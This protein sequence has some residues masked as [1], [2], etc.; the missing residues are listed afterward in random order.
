[1][2]IASLNERAEISLAVFGPKLSGSFKPALAL[3][4]GRF[5]GTAANGPVSISNFL[6]V[7]SIGLMG[8]I[9]FLL[10]YDSASFTSWRFERCD[11]F[12]NLCVLAMTQSVQARFNP[13]FDWLGLC[14]AKGLSEFQRCSLAW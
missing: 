12:E 3:P 13:S 2:I 14:T 11:L 5:G 1:M 8:K 10:L 4:T 7:H 9:D 6:V